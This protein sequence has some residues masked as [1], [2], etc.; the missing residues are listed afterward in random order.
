MREHAAQ[1]L[2]LN[3]SIAGTGFAPSNRCEP[4]NR[5]SHRNYC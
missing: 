2:L 5:D 1:A 4:S 3:P